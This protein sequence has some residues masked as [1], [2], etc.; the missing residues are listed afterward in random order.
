MPRI[1]RRLSDQDMIALLAVQ[2]TSKGKLRYSANQIAQLVGGSRA[3]VLALIKTIREGPA[4]FRPLT[5]EQQ[6]AREALGLNKREA[7]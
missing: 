1:S 6:G 2:R 4:E 7:V 5:P 3:E